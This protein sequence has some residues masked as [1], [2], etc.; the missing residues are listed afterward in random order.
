MFSEKNGYIMFEVVSALQKTIRRGDEKAAMY[1]ALEMCPR[2]EKYLWRRLI[3]IANED[4]GITD[5]HIIPLIIALRASWF[6][7]RDAGGQDE[8][9]LILAN[10]I[11]TLCRAQKSRL[12]DHFQCV[13]TSEWQ[14]DDKHDVPDY[15]LDKHTLRGSQ[16][17][18]GIEYFFDNE[19]NPLPT[20][21]YQCAAQEWWKRKMPIKMTWGVPK[22]YTDE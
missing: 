14:G 12:A 17:N 1:W 15:A 22:K 18:R 3:V 5:M 20:D 2:Y 10:A 7:L 16:M 19:D 6:V 11:L 8:C 9:R 4:I 21:E 13:V